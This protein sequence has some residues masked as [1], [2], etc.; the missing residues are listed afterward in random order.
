MEKLWY[1]LGLLAQNE[2]VPGGQD[3]LREA[4]RKS[5]GEVFRAELPYDFIEMRYQPTLAALQ[6][7]KDLFVNGYQLYLATYEVAE[8]N[9]LFCEDKRKTGNIDV[10]L[11]GYWKQL[12]FPTVDPRAGKPLLTVAGAF[13][14]DGWLRYSFTLGATDLTKF[15]FDGL[16]D[17][18]VQ[19]LRER[20]TPSGDADNFATQLFNFSWS[21]PVCPSV[22]AA[23]PTRI[24][25]CA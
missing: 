1:A 5:C 16:T 25:I 6:S 8:I 17:P 18:E 22:A 11:D 20:L 9:R 21:R 2:T 14:L 10:P 19:Q 13:I 12:G 24:H 23:F 7:I 3:K 4:V 15:G